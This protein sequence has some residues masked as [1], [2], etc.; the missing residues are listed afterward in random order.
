MEENKET[1]FELLK[2]TGKLMFKFDDDEP[3]ELGKLLNHAK[4]T[5]ELNQD[6]DNNSY[7]EFRSKE[8]KLFKLYIENIENK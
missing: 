4:F 5:I 8:G 7:A 2:E 6:D 1:T 3:H